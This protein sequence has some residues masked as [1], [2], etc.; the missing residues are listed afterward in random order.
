MTK[1]YP[2]ERYP[3]EMGSRIMGVIRDKA[4]A[5]RAVRALIHSG[6]APQDVTVVVSG[7]NEFDFKGHE[8]GVQIIRYP[9]VS[10]TGA[11][12]R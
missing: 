8:P 9:E 2:T 12:A 3:E 7:A 1:G 10:E 11:F 5:D 6:F 4:V